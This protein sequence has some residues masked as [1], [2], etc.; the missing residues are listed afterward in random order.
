M[1]VYVCI[2]VYVWHVYVRRSQA[3]V[4]RVGLVEE[5]GV[6][7]AEVGVGV[8]VDVSTPVGPRTWLRPARNF[9]ETRF[10]RSPTFLFSRQKHQNFVMF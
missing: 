5:M 9:W 3:R 2:H 8:D 1:H 7:W 6:G 10:R 4:W